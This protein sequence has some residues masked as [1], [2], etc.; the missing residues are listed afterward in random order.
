M[1]KRSF[2]LSTLSPGCKVDREVTI[3]EYRGVVMRGVMVS[4]DEQGPI[5]RSIWRA[6]IWTGLASRRTHSTRHANS[7]IIGMAVPTIF[8]RY[9][10]LLAGYIHMP[11]DCPFATYPGKQPS[12]FNDAGI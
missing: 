5:S 3:A 9:T 6:L 10:F 4:Q 2:V 1:I 7:T 11:R 12:G 8:F